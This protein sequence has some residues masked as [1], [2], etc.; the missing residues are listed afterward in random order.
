M[1][2]TPLLQ[3]QVTTLPSLESFKYENIF[4]VYQNDNNNYFYN[5]LAKT[6]FPDNLEQAYYD[7]YVV[8]YDNMPYTL[9]SYKLYGTILLWWLI[10][11][12]NKI[13]N[14]VYSPTAGTQ[15]KYL[16]PAYVRLVVSQLQDV[17]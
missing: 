7:T 12:V 15:L 9:I 3:N 8:P 6:N 5:L 17:A 11:S 2:Q 1:N 13:Q 10:C 16:T 4:N 14:P